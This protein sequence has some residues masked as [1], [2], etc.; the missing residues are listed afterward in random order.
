MTRETEFMSELE[1]ASRAK[2]HVAANIFLGAIAALVLFFILWA[3]LSRVE[4]IVQGQ[5]QVV[6]S[7]EIQ[8]VQSLEGGILAQLLAREGDRV[9]QGQVIL[10]ISD[11]HFAAEEGGVEARFASLQAR[12]ARLTAEAEGR[13]FVLPADIAEKAPAIAANEKKLYDSRQA[14]LENAL[15]MI[16]DKIAGINADIAEASAHI[17][18]LKDSAAL[19]GEELTI[20]KKMVAQQAVPKLEEI[21]LQRELSD[22]S[23]QLRAQEQKLEGLRA[24]LAAAG[25]E[26]GDQHDKFRSQALGQLG[27]V[28]TEMAQLQ[29]S[30]KSIE[31]RVFRTELRAPV[32]GIVNNIAVQTI[33]GV[34]EPA[35]KLVEIVPVDDELKI[36]ARVKPSD[37]AFLKT[38]QP[39][40]VK[41]SAYDPQRYGALDGT[42]TR[43]GA[44]SV[45]DRQDHVFFEIEVRTAKNHLGTDE[46]PLPITPGMEA[47][48]EIIIGK[49]TIMAYL[50]KP[51]LGARD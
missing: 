6:P 31:D 16:A 28:E 49:H 3:S 19:L 47:T 44:N 14:E 12:R 24:D 50:M 20:T 4:E 7:H 5:G 51:V 2:P 23:G 26:T 48:T 25:K 32:A 45:T 22:V 36:V 1:A 34:I 38:G 43:I 10:R 35:Q 40:K 27:E 15:A 8:V 33:G 18:R 41:I 37:I 9:E 39:V 42:L 30:L 29:E 46:V 17:K 21:R 11:V 13:N